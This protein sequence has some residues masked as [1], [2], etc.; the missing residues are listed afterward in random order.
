MAY[1]AASPNAYDTALIPV[2][3]RAQYFEE[4]L[5]QSPLSMF[6]GDS[7]ESVIQVVYKKD[8]TGS[9]TTFSFSRELDY[10]SEIYD[11]DQ[12][13][14]KGQALK[15]YEDTITVRQ[16]SRADQL[17]G[18]QLVQL[19][20]PIDI[21]NAL[22][23]KLMTAHKRNITYSLLKSATFDSYG[24]AFT[25]GPITDRVQY[26]TGGTYN[27]NMI[28]AADAL[29][30]GAYG[31]GGL[32]VQGI[33]NLRD[34]AVQGGNS[35]E[36]DKRISPFMLKT[37]EG[38]PYPM[39]VYF[40]STASYKSLEQ[41]PDW[42]GF[43]N[44]GIIEMPNQPSS[45]VGSF[46]RGQIDGVLIYEVPELG[47]FKLGTAQGFARDNAWNLFCGAQAFGLVWHK[48]PWFEQEFSNMKTVVEM[49][50]L[51]FRG[52]KAIKFPSFQNEA[53]AIENGIIHHIVRLT[54]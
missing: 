23:P 10:K 39:Y 53:V 12:I 16:R 11:Y 54:A 36:V 15:F 19:N 35:F 45:L 8:G 48:E 46:F 43:Y 49:A 17:K 50:M 51:E 38:F 26:G 27:A 3:V 20:T 6:M 52:E 32:S 44:R 25:A 13:S 7:P 40:M 9:T 22:K 42:K 18:I 2:E 14:G 37:R 21:Y 29:A 1:T 5:L 24:S 30:G 33:K 4:V 31:T 47:N 28:T 41:D 34:M